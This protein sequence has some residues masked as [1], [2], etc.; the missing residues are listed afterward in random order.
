MDDSMISTIGVIG[1]GTMGRQIAMLAAISGFRTHCLDINPGQVEEARSFTLNYL[2]GRVD[3]GRL[4]DEQARKA[5]SSIYF[6]TD[7]TEPLK[8]VDF[9]IEAAVEK[10]EV[11][12]ELFSQLDRYCP[13]HAILATN[14][15]YIVSSRIADATGRPEKV[16]NMHFFNPA[17]VMKCVEV[18][19]GVHTSE[20]TAQVAVGLARRLNKEPVLLN[21][22]IYGFLV[23][24]IFSS[25]TTEA[26]YLIDMGIASP[27]DI[28]SA[29]VNA[30]GHPM[31]PCRLMD[32]NGLDFAYIRRMERYRETNDPADKPAA[33]LVEKYARG[34]W[35]K[36]TGKGFFEYEKE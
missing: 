16:C 21:K 24:R 18:V 30:L 1:A 32:M 28:D 15:S 31:G 22:E 34:E 5:G 7:L 36:K 10:L 9:V 27:E 26:L 13:K 35:G 4:T 19:K 29:V 11:K 3:K 12:R 6:S 23:N 2:Q 33:I 20:E 25:I 17:L 8:E 14:S